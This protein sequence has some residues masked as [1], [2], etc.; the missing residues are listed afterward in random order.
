MLPQINAQPRTKISAS[1]RQLSIFL[2]GL[3]EKLLIIWR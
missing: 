1:A 3:L 2:S